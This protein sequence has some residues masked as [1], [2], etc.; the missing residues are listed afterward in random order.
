VLIT[1]PTLPSLDSKA[2]LKAGF[3]QRLNH[4]TYYTTLFD[5]GKPNFQKKKDTVQVERAEGQFTIWPCA[6]NGCPFAR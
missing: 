1:Q 4:C 3:H 2:I 5:F 6:A